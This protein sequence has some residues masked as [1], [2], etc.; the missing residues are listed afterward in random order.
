MEETSLP[1]LLSF[2]FKFT[3]SSSQVVQPQ[4]SSLSMPNSGCGCGGNLTATYKGCGKW[5]E[6]KAA[7]V[8]R[9][10]TGAVGKSGAT[11]RAAKPAQTRYEPSAEQ[12]SLGEGWSQVVRGGRVV[13]ATPSPSPAAVAEAL[14]R[15]KQK[16]QA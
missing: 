16:G 13:Q 4:G 11:G 12:L 1:Y 10:P 15:H 7:F 3:A 6:A 2:N 8:T 14:K 9:A 5:K